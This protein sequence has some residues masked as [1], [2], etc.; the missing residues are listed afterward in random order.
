MSTHSKEP[1][2]PKLQEG[3][4]RKKKKGS[5]NNGREKVYFLT[6]YSLKT[7]ILKERGSGTGRSTEMM[8]RLQYIL[9]RD[10]I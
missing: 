5:K 6:T 1:N 10:T 9:Y 7:V 4:E 3:S 8:L 2:F